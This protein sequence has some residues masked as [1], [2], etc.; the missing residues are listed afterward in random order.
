MDQFINIETTETGEQVKFIDSRYYTKDHEHWFPGIS[1][2][3]QTL[4]KG[5]Q[6][7]QWLKGMGFN[8]DYLAHKAMA[9]GSNVHQA[10]QYLC[11]GKELKFGT[12]EKGA[13]YTREEW[14]MISRFIDFYENFKPK[15]IAV[16]KV[17]VSDK[18]KFGSQ[19]DLV[20]EL[21]GE[22]WIIDHK[23]GSLYDTAQMQLS[24]YVQLW[25]EYFPT[26][27]AVKCGVLHLESA[28]RGRDKAG[29]S[30]QGQGWKL[31]EVENIEN[32]WEDFKHIQA[33]WVRQNK[34]YKPFN[35]TY[36]ATYKLSNICL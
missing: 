1:T 12:I 7:E 24:A 21:N 29:K 27:K 20:V 23:T 35:I 17:I 34:D 18:L 6:Y 2:I 31:V 25:N 16:E 28:H 10:I 19:L 22:V 13:F 5:K 11:D 15:I 14:I 30:I 8:A 26:Q 33:L 3:L 9:Q 32:N 4:N 36:P